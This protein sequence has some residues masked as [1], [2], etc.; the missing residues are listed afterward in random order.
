VAGDEASGGGADGVWGL[1][2]VADSGVIIRNGKLDR[3]G[4][5]G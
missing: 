4:M 3:R 2:L 1:R 5:P